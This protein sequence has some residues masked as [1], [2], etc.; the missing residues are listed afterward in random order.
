VPTL[1]G[2]STIGIPSPP[3]VW[4]R[5]AEPGR[6]LVMPTIEDAEALQGF[7]RG[8]TA[9][10]AELGRRGEGMR[11]KLVGN[12]VTVGASRWLGRRLVTQ[13]DSLA[14]ATPLT[15]KWPTSAWGA[16]G[17]AFDAGLS[18]WPVREPYEHLLDV[19]NVNE[20]KP[21]SFRGATGFLS[22]LER[23]TLRINPEFMIAVKEHVDAVSGGEFHRSA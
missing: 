11:W 17:K 21:L 9:P 6:A 7:P 15:G 4:I 1:R 3:G 23:S 14:A 12:A 5:G 10:A 18:L 13:G 20:A 19:L 22:R 16:K 8:W 2:G